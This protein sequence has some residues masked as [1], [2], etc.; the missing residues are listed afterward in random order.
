MISGREALGSI[1]QALNQ[2]HQKI[3]AVEQ[4]IQGLT[5]ALI[6]QQRAQT[7][8]YRELAKVRL[9]KLTEAV[10]G[11]NL[12]QADRQVMSLLEQ[13]RSALGA[14]E[15]K[16]EG[17][18]ADHQVLEAERSARAEEV[19]LAAA[20]V[21]D[22]EAAT[23]TRLDADPVYRAQRART[24]AAERKAMHATEKAA[25]SEEERQAKGA[26]YRSDPLFMYLWERNY[27]LPG[28]AASALI[29]WLDGKVARLIGFADA[30]AN[31]ARLNE[32]PERLRQHAEG[33]ES[34]AATEFAALKAL[35]E[36]AR[37]ADGVPAL[38]RAL[39]VEQAKLDE[40]DRRIEQWESAHRAR[41]DQREAFATGDDEYTRQAT[42]FLTAE[43]Q[44]DDLVQLRSEA[45]STPYPEDDVIVS[46]MQQR[47]LER[48]NAEAT[49]AGLTQ[50][51][52]QQQ[53]RLIELERL[54]VDFKH[55]RYDRAGSTFGDNSL[56]A[57][58]L[59]QFLDGLL[60]RRMLWQVLQE[61][62][63]YRPRRSDPT[64]GSGGFGRGTVWNGGLGD[65]GDIF[66]GMGRGGFGRRGGGGF[67][68]GGGGG[69]FR[70]GGGF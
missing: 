55:A 17:G 56:V 64:F 22:A 41:L 68:R 54:R 40:V 10:L 32:I 25:R 52:R 51:N 57:L 60:D 42:T 50:T 30:R 34:A 44:R 48:Q 67:G 45:M 2:V 6:D 20:A 35:D 66:G 28:Y 21:D 31:F 37:V 13:R 14:L 29:R 8:D 70:T 49:L 63:R 23:Q 69:G 65:I 9:G 33:L 27:G 39:E 61:Q 43:L 5:E 26:A 18:I 1:D 16:I 3:Q 46:R 12:E 58:M 36:A 11:T 24:E 38:E 19:D 7:E 59:S 47:E 4:Q 15:A 62:Q 53:Q